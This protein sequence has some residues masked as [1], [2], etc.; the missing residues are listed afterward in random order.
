[1]TALGDAVRDIATD[2]VG[3]VTGREGRRVRL[4]P[5]ADGREWDAEAC[6][7]RPMGQSE[8]LSALLAELNAR[9]RR[10]L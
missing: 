3:R 5:L 8:L 9:S 4:R 10:T 1:M 7:L 2:R 6:H